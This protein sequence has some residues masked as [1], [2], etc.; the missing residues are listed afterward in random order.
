MRSL[1]VT[2][3]VCLSLV[4]VVE[5]PAQAGHLDPSFG[6]GG[7]QLNAP[8]SLFTGAAVAPN[9]DIVVAGEASSAATFV[10]YLPNGV[11]DASFGGSGTVSLPAPSNFFLGTS[12]PLAMAIQNDGKILMTYYAFNNTS[13]LSEALLIRLDAN[14]QIDTTFGAGGQVTLSFPTPTGWGASATKV[15]QQ[16]D[17]K[18][19]V[20]GNIVP[21][22][23]NHSAPLTVLA[24][25]LANGAPDTSFGTDGVDEV[26]TAVDLPT[27][28]ALLSGD[29]ILALN[30]QGTITTAQFTSTGA[31]VSPTT[32]GAIVEISNNGVTALENN[33]DYLV[34]GS[35]LGADGKTNVDADVKRFLLNGTLDSTFQSPAIRFAPDATNTKTLLAGVAVDSAGRIAV[36]GE[37]ESANFG[38]AVA[39]LNPNGTLDTTFGSGGVG[40]LVP[41]FVAYAVL[42][43]TDNKIVMVGGTGQLARYL[44]Q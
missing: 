33:G 40:T 20:T 26:V 13:T 21:P 3:A 28:V 12:F 10:R 27:S 4:A 31:L 43:Q 7:V 5:A 1:I 39:R 9:G 32:G 22:F 14:G 16:P 42:V 23:R 37:L 8:F 19:L 24:R 34:G 30:G 38:S 11:P 15:L 6:T 29:G 35:V 18:I 2:G 44:A 25:Y 36:I 17:G 41:G